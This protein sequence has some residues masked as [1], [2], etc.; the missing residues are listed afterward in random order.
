[1]FLHRPRCAATTGELQLQVPLALTY[2]L[3]RLAPGLREDNQ[4]VR[5]LVSRRLSRY[6][7]QNDPQRKTGE[8]YILLDGVL[9]RPVK[10]LGVKTS[11]VFHL[12][13]ADRFVSTETSGGSEQRARTIRRVSMSLG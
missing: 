1:M 6:P 7:K 5:V 8:P 12:G 13:W 2:S 11:G 9:D 4:V 3:L 10:P